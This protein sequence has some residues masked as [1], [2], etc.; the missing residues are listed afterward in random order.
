MD[1]LNNSYVCVYI[2]FTV[3]ISIPGRPSYFFL[4]PFPNAHAHKR[5]IRLACEITLHVRISD[6]KMATQKADYSCSVCLELFDEP[7]VLP[8]CHTFCLKCLQKTARSA[9]KKGEITCPQCR[10]T[11]AIPAGGLAVLLTDFIATYEL[12]VTGLKSSQS[13]GAIKAL[14]C[15]E[16]E[17]AGPVESYCR[18]CRNYLCRECGSQLH[19]ILKAYRGHKVVPIQELD[20]ASLQLSQVQYC[21]KHKSEAVN[22]FCQTCVKL[23][24]RDCALVDHRQ[25]SYKFAHDARK[26]IEDKLVALGQSVTQKTRVFKGNLG[27]IE[28]VETA[29]VSYSEVLKADINLFFDKLIQSIE[30]RR[31][32]LLTGAEAECQKDLKQ[33]WADK[34]FHQTTL[35]Q[36]A[37]VLRLSEKARK[38]TSDIDMILTALQSIRQL[39]QLKETE[40]DASAFIRV[41]TSPAKFTGGEIIATDKTGKLEHV[42]SLDFQMK[43]VNKPTEASL[44]NKVSFNVTYTKPLSQD[45]IDKRS[46]SPICLQSHKYSQAADGLK[47]IVKYGKSQKE[48]D[49]ALITYREGKQSKSRQK[50]AR[51]G[52]EIDYKL[53]PQSQAAEVSHQCSVSIRLVCGGS[54]TVAFKVG[55]SEVESCKFSFF[56]FGR[57]QHGALVKKGPDWQDL[58]V[59]KQQTSVDHLHKQQT[60]VDHLHKQQTSVDHL[61]KQQTSVDHLH[62]QQ[63]S[64]DHLHK[65]QTS[66][67]HL[68]KQQTSVDHL[69]KQQTSVDHLHKQQTSVDH[70]HKQQTSVDHLQAF[71]QFPHDKSCSTESDID[72]MSTADE[73]GTVVNTYRQRAAGSYYDSVREVDDYDSV[74]KADDG[75]VCVRETSGSVSYYTWGQNDGYE[76]EL[77]R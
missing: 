61:H 5:K 28:K 60:S 4:H 66:V 43:V 57:P 51:K 14:T 77:V 64:V 29:A 9:Q 34:V 50:P 17:R 68:H 32:V 24:C 56:V 3:L 13:S 33:I 2:Q 22:L 46:G 55:Y 11:H 15:G 19:K 37:A 31:K 45:L 1:S 36:I 73:V 21:V 8:C 48:L 40:W 35:S 76:I 70:L 75:D 25:H 58:K 52:Q 38:C 69:H 53:V 65:Q 7:K 42:S 59:R 18:D 12:E 16:C 41:A 63:T 49:N 71:S 39:S 23:I 10:K 62:K 72:K 30:A 54:H 44:G 74:R 20:A 47:I 6:Y 67:D 27:E 26:D